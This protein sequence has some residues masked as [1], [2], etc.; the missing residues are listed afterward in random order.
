MVQIVL[1]LIRIDGKIESLK[2]H[3]DSQLRNIGGNLYSWGG[4]TL[5]IEVGLGK[6]E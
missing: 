5:D 6:P 2:M 4:P 1:G 3:E